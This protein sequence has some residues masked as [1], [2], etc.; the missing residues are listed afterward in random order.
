MTIFEKYELHKQHVQ[1]MQEIEEQIE[2]TGAEAGEEVPMEAADDKARDP[3]P[4]KR[5]TTPRAC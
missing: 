1:E 5:T 4:G 2:G 3:S